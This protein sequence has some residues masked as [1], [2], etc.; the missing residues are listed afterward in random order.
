LVEEDR[1]QKKVKIIRAVT[2]RNRLRWI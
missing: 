1:V 2:W